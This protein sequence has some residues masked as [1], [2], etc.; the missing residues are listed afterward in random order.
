VGRIITFY[1]YK[2]GTGR[3][4]ALAHVA[5]LLASAGKRVLAVDW[6]LEAPGLHRYFYPFLP[7]P[8]LTNSDGII[9][10]VVDFRDEAF[11]A[12]K[13]PA[14]K[15][16]F[17][18]YA[19]ILRYAA[20]LNYKFPG[21]G[22][23]DFVAAGRQGPEYSV[24]VNTF[25]WQRFYEDLG[26]GVFL[27][28]VRHSMLKEYEYVL[29]DSRTGVSDTSGIC[30]VQMPDDLVV[31]FTL[32]NQSIEGA[33]RVAS[34]IAAKRTAGDAKEPE[35][36]APTSAAEK[37][38]IFPVPMRVEEAERD[39]LDL[40]REFARERFGPFLDHLDLERRKTYWDNTEI[41]YKPWYAY[42]E[43]LA[44]FGDRPGSPTTL[45]ASMERLCSHLTGGQ[46]EEAIPVDE[47]ERQSVL[48]AYRKRAIDATHTELEARA[49]ALWSRLSPE[50]QAASRRLLLRLVRVPSP[51]IGGPLAST[52][53]PA[54][55]LGATQHQAAIL[56]GEAN[57]LDE[58][59]T[60]GE[61]GFALRDVE[62]MT[63]WVRAREWITGDWEFLFWRQK[64]RADLDEWTKGGKDADALLRGGPLQT[65][66]GWLARRA[67]ELSDA[68][69]GYIEVSSRRPAW[70]SSNWLAASATLAALAWFGVDWAQRRQH[71]RHDQLV[72]ESALLAY[73]ADSLALLGENAAAI[74]LYDS[75]LNVLPSQAAVIARRAT[76]LDATG[77]TAAAVADFNAAIAIDSNAAP[78]WYGRARLR[79][80][81]GDSLLA[82]RDVTR[83]LALDS[84]NVDSY[85][86]RGRILTIM[87]EW[88]E[89]IASFT[90]GLSRDTVNVELLLAR[91][92]AYAQTNQKTNAIADYRHVIVTAPDLRD[93]DVAEARLKLLNPATVARPVTIRYQVDVFLADTVGR[94]VLLRAFGSA[95]GRWSLGAVAYWRRTS[96]SEVRYA[97]SED[98][99]A[100]G[101]LANQVV[102]AFAGAGY[103]L[104]LG[105]AVMSPREQSARVA[106]AAGVGPEGRR[107][108]EL[109]L[110]PL[111]AAAA[112]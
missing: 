31:C 47:T 110:P 63:A 32:N 104:R 28:A 50:V 111:A 23:L 83:A 78:A 84:S 49:E 77:D 54:K 76:L 73:S 66:Q 109:W 86:L 43:V 64:L 52:P 11:T 59:R 58:T 30:T 44:T 34:V 12:R 25:D 106:S 57:L 42:E 88:P 37:F 24:H 70:K 53:F 22:T 38:R 93:R 107:V 92:Y 97:R 26:G 13:S 75:A 87:R 39:K 102:K 90:H 82:L 16:W 33:S 74:T 35:S 60:G 21:S 8:E 7:D 62:L 14:D 20:S 68:E 69:R 100:A 46:V 40:R 17:I 55:E 99:G 45:L 3:S 51:D 9:D 91:G 95:V 15:E 89:A 19:N 85:L 29:I 4:M 10:L 36:G 65:A 56:W 96:I 112:R 105:V 41:F 71:E 6:D 5:W 18:P 48:A 2:G 101:E 108:L 98:A 81:T 94:G 27:N 61:A 1:S 67:D 80:R 79:F 72:A 103:R